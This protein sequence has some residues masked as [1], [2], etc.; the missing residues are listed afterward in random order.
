MQD[1]FINLELDTEVLNKV[2]NK[3]DNLIN[4]DNS[5]K[6]WNENLS[7]LAFEKYLRE[8]NSNLDIDI[9]SIP[10]SLEDETKYR[11]ELF[12]L[13]YLKVNNQ[14]VNVIPV[15]D[16]SKKEFFI[17][18]NIFDSLHHADTFSFIYITPLKTSAYLLG[19]LTYDDIDSNKIYFDNH[20]YKLNISNL[21][22]NIQ[23][24]LNISTSRTISD[25]IN[26]QEKNLIE[27]DLKKQLNELNSFRNDNF[28]DELYYQPKNHIQSFLRYDSLSKLYLEAQNVF[29]ENMQLKNFSFA[30][31]L[32]NSLYEH[33]KNNK[34]NFENLIDKNFD[35]SSIRY[36]NNLL[37]T[38]LEN[39]KDIF[40]SI[41]RSY[42]NIDLNN[43][44]N[45]VKFINNLNL[46]KN[47]DFF[48]SL[49]E[50]TLELTKNTSL[51][52]N[53][54]IDKI[55]NKIDYI[56]NNKVELKFILNVLKE[57]LEFN[58]AS[59]LSKVESTKSQF[60]KENS[61]FDIVE[62]LINESK[63]DIYIEL[64]SIFVLIIKVLVNKGYLQY[65]SKLNNIQ[66]ACIIDSVFFV[67]SLLNNNKLSIKDIIN[68]IVKR[69]FSI[70]LTYISKKLEVDIS[71]SIE[72]IVKDLKNILHNTSLLLS[73]ISVYY[74][75]ANKVS[76]VLDY[77]LKA[78]DLI[79]LDD[80]NKQNTNKNTLNNNN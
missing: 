40:R 80:T 65:F 54:N 35:N 27:V 51:S 45:L 44:D 36:F 31:D 3:V 76:Q 15:L 48:I 38:E 1:N 14:Y 56:K 43:F 63:D 24:L 4:K 62:D 12:N 57:Q 68:Q 79:K 72:S 18:K 33:Y 69:N 9:T 23:D 75:N 52:N 71:I 46:S 7:L 37:I 6:V 66:I 42:R 67:T 13:N 73:F 74:P 10:D 78:L 25:S 8:S 28:V 20:F 5:E 30:S 21:K 64:K 58:F 11:R 2:Q 60:R 29:Q 49:L 22:T 26:N 17:P 61:K 59:E 39:I 16:P 53:I 32:A 34:N 41:S 77:T 55:S 50:N 70:I 19:Y 47:K